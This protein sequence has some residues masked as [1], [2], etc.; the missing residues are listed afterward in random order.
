MGYYAQII[1]YLQYKDMMHNPPHTKGAIL[2]G[3][4]WEKYSDIVLYFTHTFN[5]GQ[6]HK[7]PQSTLQLYAYIM[8]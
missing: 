6:E 3:C 2:N 1:S 8:P 4:L 7:A 5:M